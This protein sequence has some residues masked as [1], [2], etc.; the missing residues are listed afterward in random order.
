[1]NLRIGI[2]Y[3]VLVSLFLKVSELHERLTENM[4]ICAFFDMV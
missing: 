4:G 3:I 2:C 1:M